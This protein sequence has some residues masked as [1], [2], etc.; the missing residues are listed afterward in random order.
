MMEDRRG[1]TRTYIEPYDTG[2]SIGFTLENREYQF[3]LLD[4]SPGGIGMLVT[5]EEK[6]V[7]KKIATGDHIKMHY[8]DPDS[9]IP[10][11]F[12]IRHITEVERGAFEG[13]HLVGLCLVSNI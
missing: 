7:L 1:P 11:N 6:E 12:Q 3:R 9:R 13:H 2:T 5:K 4:T 10:M 8:G